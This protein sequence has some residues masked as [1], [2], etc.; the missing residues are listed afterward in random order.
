MVYRLRRRL[1]V[2]EDIV[3][4]NNVNND[5]E[6]K[7][8][9]IDDV[10]DADV[11]RQNQQDTSP[12]IEAEKAA[13]EMNDKTNE[14][15]AVMNKVNEID[16]GKGIFDTNPM[17]IESKKNVDV[18]VDANMM[19]DKAE[20]EITMNQ[21]NGINPVNNVNSMNNLKDGNGNVNNINDVNIEN[22]HHR[23][24]NKE[25]SSH[26]LLN[27]YIF[28]VVSERQLIFS[29]IVFVYPCTKTL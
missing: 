1:L 9:S 27:L 6:N 28:F 4:T 14:N 29:F 8:P 20:N 5:A 19:D 21:D 2:A 16:S 24:N 3:N 17:N 11:S 12:A 25:A 13:D 22:V 26:S 10:N 23:L 7:K 18:K 15:N